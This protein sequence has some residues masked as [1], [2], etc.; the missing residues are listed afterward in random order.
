MPAVDDEKIAHLQMNE[1][2]YLSELFNENPDEED[3]EGY[4]GSALSFSLFFAG[5]YFLLKFG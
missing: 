5:F 1:S 2:D 3:Y 4:M